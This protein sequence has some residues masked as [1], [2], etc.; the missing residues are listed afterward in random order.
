MQD[1][2]TSNIKMITQSQK[3]MLFKTYEY[4]L[5]RD[6]VEVCQTPASSR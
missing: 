6:Y 1:N 3:Q 4:S 5:Y 2:K